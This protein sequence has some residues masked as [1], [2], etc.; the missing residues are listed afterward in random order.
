MLFCSK[1]Q[2]HENYHHH[3][4]LNMIKTHLQSVLSHNPHHLN[5]GSVG[6]G[7]HIKSY[8]KWIRNLEF[9]LI[10]PVCALKS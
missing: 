2:W 9:G 1:Q 8:N 5:G 6:A 3:H 7:G 10:L 4:H